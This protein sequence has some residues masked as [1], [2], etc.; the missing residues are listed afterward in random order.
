MRKDMNDKE[1]F[2]RY[3]NS[4]ASDNSPLGSEEETNTKKI[5]KETSQ[6]KLREDENQEAV[7]NIVES[8]MKTPTAKS[9]KIWHILRVAASIVAV[10]GVVFYLYN[11]QSS[12]GLV[13]FETAIGENRKIEL[14]D[15][16]RVQL[17]VMSSLSYNESDW[18]KQRMV[19][20]DGKAYFE[21]KAGNSFVVKSTHGQTQV[22]GTSFSV[23][24]RRKSFHVECYTGKVGVKRKGAEEILMPGKS[25]QLI[26][27]KLVVNSIDIE[28][29]RG[30]IKGKI[31]FDNADL[32]DVYKALEMNYPVK[33]KSQLSST[34]YFTGYINTKQDLG[35]NL[36][37]LSLAMGLEVKQTKEN[38]FVINEAR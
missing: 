21:V 22:L 5:L 26:N 4:R 6:W 20:L 18:G 25:I 16:S 8:K 2:E 15:G 10:L 31:H 27:N 1:L 19:H 12:R 13:K 37:R 11:L 35:R 30:W 3:K 29:N 17:D 28:K 36:D 9:F 34:K 32:K 33:I 23:E 7:W 38:L 14:P 24:D